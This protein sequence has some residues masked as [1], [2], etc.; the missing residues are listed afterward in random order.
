VESFTRVLSLIQERQPSMSFI[1]LADIP[2]FSASFSW[3]SPA[4]SRCLLMFNERVFRRVWVL[5]LILS[6]GTWLFW[7]VTP[8][9][10]S[11]GLAFS[12]SFRYIINIPIVT[13][14]AVGVRCF[15][16][17]FYEQRG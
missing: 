1:M 4:F 6:Y 14:K 13:G 7:V 11:V 12:D 5:S 15:M 2:A 16:V 8:D 17:L 10:S 9:I 3:V